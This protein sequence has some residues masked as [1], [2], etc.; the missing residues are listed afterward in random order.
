MNNHVKTIAFMLYPRLTPLDLN[1]PL[2]VMSGLEVLEATCGM[3][4]RHQALEDHP[5]LLAW[6]IGSQPRN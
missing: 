6:L 5:D 1:G 3:Q 4:S 2:Q